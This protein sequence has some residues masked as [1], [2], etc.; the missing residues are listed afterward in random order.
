MALLLPVLVLAGCDRIPAWEPPQWEE[1]DGYR[2]H[3]LE[4]PTRGG[5]GFTPMSVRRTGIDFENIV[6]P[7]SALDH[8]HLMIGSGVALGDVNG[9]GLVDIYF[10]R[11]EGPNVLYRNLGGWRFEEMTEEAGVA[12]PDVNSTGAVFVDVNGNGALD[13]VVT[14][15]GGPN[16]LFLN[17]GE[18]H[19]TPVDE[20]IGADPD[21]GSTTVTI[22][23]VDGSGALDLYIA[24]YKVESAADIY[25]PYENPDFR[26]TREEGDSVIIAPEYREH[27]VW[28]ER[29]GQRVAVEQ[30]HPDR[31]LMNDGEGTFTREAWDAGRFLDQEGN[32]V[33]RIKHDFALAARFYDVTGNGAPDLYV[34]NDF[35]D[36]D[37]FW[38]NDGTGTFHEIP[39]L[40][41]R[42]TSHASM[43]I[44]FADLDRNG[45]IDFFVADML[46]A[47]PRRRVEQQPLHSVGTTPPGQVER[48]TQFQRNA[49]HFQRSDGTFAQISD[50]A[51][52]DATEWTW[53]SLFLD[54]DL[55]GY[56]DLLVVNGPGRD[57]QNVDAYEQIMS[58]RGQISWRDARALYP[59]LA[60]PNMAF[61][62]RG[63]LTFDDMTQAWD[64]GFESDVS[65]GIAVGDLSGNGALDVVVNRMGA[66][67]AILR[68]DASAPRVA[69]RLVGDGPNTRGVGAKVRVL[70]G[71]VPVQEREMT[72]GGLYLSHSDYEL[73]FAAGDAEAVT[74][75]V[76]W[77]SGRKSVIADVPPNRRYEIH[78]SGGTEG[79]EAKPFQLPGHTP[80]DVSPLFEDATEL[81]GGHTHP[82]EH[83]DDFRRQPLLPFEVA[84]LD[85][86]IGWADLDGSGFPDL[87]VPPGAGGRL[88]ILR[89]RGGSFTT[90][91]LEE[92]DGALDR[93]GVA[94]LPHGDGERALLVGN[95]NWLA[96]A[97]QD[98]TTTPSVLRVDPDGSISPAIP[99]DFSSTGPLAVADV[100]GDGTLDL[101]VGG[102]A[103]PSLYPRAASS[104]LFLG[105]SD[106]GDFVLHPDSERLFSD[107]GLVSGAVFSDLSGN[108]APD[109][110][111]AIEWGSPR[112]FL[113]DG[114]GRFEETTAAWG[115]DA[116]EGR[117]NGVATGD[118]T[119]DGRMDVVLTNWGRNMKNRPLPDRP[120][121][122]YHGDLDGSGGWDMLLA[123]PGADGRINPVERYER[124]R[125]AMPSLRNRIPDF[126]TYA[127]AEID[128]ILGRD[129]A[130]VPRLR[131][132][133]YDH[134]V[135]L[136]TGEGFEAHPLPVQAQFAP[137]FAPVIFDAD[138]NG[139][140]DLFLAQNFFAVEPYTPRH[141]AG[142]GL[143]LRGDGAGGFEAVPGIE[144]GIRIHGDQ[145]GAAV[146]DFDGDGRVDLAVAQNGGETRLYRNVGA[147]P[148]LRVRLVGPPG[149]PDAIGA[150]IRLVYDDG[151][152]PIREIQ[153]A[154][155]YWSLNDPVQVLGREGEPV[156]VQVHW[157]GSVEAE[158]HPVEPGA[159]E[160]TIRAG[161]P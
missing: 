47:D 71:P 42:A 90:E 97:A 20:W 13:L 143:L 18:G 44:D 23:D 36:R 88:S 146:A 79:W 16:T 41:L 128:E 99:G 68:N 107:V 123:Q 161:D 19:F 126:A 46:S 37:N 113:N 159:R 49:L 40:A 10:A 75:E 152:G 35:D 138:G 94:L 63:D 135:L 155:G 83:Y 149:N 4:V 65:H 60:T 48:R 109:L 144:S 95:S 127:A 7:E 115:I 76:L 117:W 29:D 114:E 1:G 154:S 92:E 133:T 140:E 131:A 69:V 33:E 21:L 73:V 130:S 137:A 124:L 31:L 59:E 104:R 105:S 72:A 58:L 52:V 12:L 17:D 145:R 91:W 160:V 93:T 98:L 14:A 148:G 108:G 121:L 26:L 39:I 129:P 153:G 110:L 89:N 82:E 62:N 150:R 151:E 118:L 74:L 32:P 64:F 85:P 139:R 147:E 66:P 67:A 6:H 43:S 157:P 81:L 112:L 70:G 50:L 15:L 78:E 87:I 156:A 158:R 53:G 141:D 111:L 84:R 125:D 106:G 134:M 45:R 132:A 5:P 51:G 61:R 11:M 100:D 56:E 122:L 80:D 3:E 103:I 25:R 54:V 101:F 30:A 57:T 9:N 102:R 28:V 27:F 55:D 8:E 136:N 96:A 120:L 77:P 142:R 2:W 34:A 116:L 22:A 119:G 86:G 24:G 38:L